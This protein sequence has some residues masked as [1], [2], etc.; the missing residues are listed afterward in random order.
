PE[1]PHRVFPDNANAYC[2][3]RPISMPSTI[4]D[5][6]NTIIIIV[7]GV[8]LAAISGDIG[9]LIIWICRKKVKNE[10]NT[11]KMTMALTGLEDNEPL[12]QSNVAPNCKK[13]RTIKETEIRRGDILGQGAFGI[14]YK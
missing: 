11:L 12:R 14:V 9:I 7:V 8:V 2:S 1:Y 6:R 5:D 10:E 4:G 13:L 3:D